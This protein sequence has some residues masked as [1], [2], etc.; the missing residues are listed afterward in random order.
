MWA[1]VTSPA[2][3]FAVSTA[4]SKCSSGIAASFW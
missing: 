3:A 2:D 4:D 1:L